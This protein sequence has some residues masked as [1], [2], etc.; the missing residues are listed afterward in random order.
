[1]FNE[2]LPCVRRLF[3]PPG[4]C[5]PQPPTTDREG[6]LQ[7]TPNLGIYPSRP[8]PSISDIH[9]E[10]C[11]NVDPEMQPPTYLALSTLTSTQMCP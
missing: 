3:T 9:S 6:N 4:A 2:L 1:M 8:F 5:P 11:V 10:L 7:M